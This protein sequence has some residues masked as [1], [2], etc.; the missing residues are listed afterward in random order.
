MGKRRIKQSNS[1]VS[2][3][4]DTV[5]LLGI[6]IAL[7]SV[8]SIVALSYP[9]Q[10]STPSTNIIGF[11]DGNNIILEHRGG[12]PLSLDTKILIKIGD[13]E[14]SPTA[15]D[16]LSDTNGDGHWNLDER[17][18]FN[19]GYDISNADIGVTVVDVASNSVVMMAGGIQG[20][21]TTI[22]SLETH[23]NPITP[24]N[25]G[26]SPFL[27]TA[28]GD[29][30]LNSVTLWY[31]WSKDNTSWNGGSRDWHND[32][33]DSAGSNVDGSLDKG[34]E[35]SFLNAQE[36]ARDGDYMTVQEANQGNENYNYV[37]AQSSL[38]PPT[39]IG[40]HSSFA[41]MQDFDGSYD[42]LSEKNTTTPT[43]DYVDVANAN[44][45]GTHSDFTAE[46]SGPNGVF[47]TLSEG[48]TG[49]SSTTK[50]IDN[51]SFEGTWPPTGWSET[52]DGNW[53]RES[54]QVY[55][56]TYSADWD[57]D[58]SGYLYS[59]T[60]SCSGSS[61]I[62][63]SFYFKEEVSDSDEFR[64]YF[65]DAD[66]NYD[67]IENLGSY[68]SGWNH[69]TMTITDSQYFS[70]N[71]QI[72]WRARNVDSGEHIYVDLVYVTKTVV[73]P[74]YELNLEVQWTSVDYTLPN[75]RLSIYAGTMASED[76]KVDIWNTTTSNWD[77]ALSDLT[78][79]WNNISV[80]KWLTSS[81]FTIRYRDGTP[82]SDSTPSTWQ[83]DVTLLRL[84]GNTNYQL[85]LEVQWTSADYD[86]TNEYLCIYGGTQ[87]SESLRVDVWNGA[88]TNVISDLSAGWNNVSVSSYLT[89][90]NFEIRF[91]DTTQSGDTS[92][93][94]WQ[95]EGVLL[96]TWSVATN[97]QIDF[98]YQW[99]GAY[100]NSQSE[101]LCMYIGSH[102]GSETLN[103]NYRS[104]SSW[105]SLGTIT[106][107]GWNNFTATGL[108]SST[109]TIQ[110]IG[111]TETSDISQDTWTVDC[112]FLKTYNTSG[113]SNG[114]DWMIW[115][116]ITNPDTV[117]PWS[118]SFNFPDGKGYYEFYSIGRYGGNTEAAPA[119]ADA[120]CHYTPLPL[121]VILRP[122]AA[123]STTDL[124]RSGSGGS[125][126]D[127]VDEVTSDED[128]TYVYSN[129]D[130]SF[131]TDTYNLENPSLTG[132]ITKV[133]VYINVRRNSESGGPTSQV[134]ARTATR[135]SS[136]S[137][138]YGAT[139]PDL[140]TSWTTYSTE[141]TTKQGNLGSG[142]WTWTDIN[143]LQIGVSLRSQNDYYSWN[144]HWSWA[145]C[146][147]VW[148][149]VTYTS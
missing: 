65:R 1:A 29:S 32:S 13:Q 81:T 43:I 123:G 62:Y 94:S 80:T 45:K 146:T 141:Y 34:T 149:E 48:N 135:I 37:D 10:P 101:T 15:K 40:T 41:E 11:V 127:R 79:G 77:N 130:G 76:I 47:D 109:Y 14:Y 35:T 134:S 91:V 44:N 86:E 144:D 131:R 115:Y 70:S 17:F 113:G 147:Q 71:F 23:V 136:G 106:A 58:G 26:S 6:A 51:Q 137:I 30:G 2:E 28:T 128:S 132:T 133:T 139:T 140:S 60:M 83:I 121:S 118:W 143:N 104:G 7:F 119:V 22:P 93:S 107:A 64:L 67:L 92:Q 57:D 27:I 53:N 9:F 102:T 3:V 25:Q 126:W 42:T 73:T 84:L 39:D 97:Y 122:N 111:A 12:E 55:H 56:G 68:P 129:N 110:L 8:V 120:R 20:E 33:V 95:V 38:H 138:E 125:N 103:V 61:S 31:R 78:T 54:D 87:D 69:W 99:T 117:S 16:N 74:N 59:P 4:L 46:Q 124:S 108:T 145:W 75:E 89:S 52:G 66:G 148:V 112:M 82:T 36:I 63:V 90:S 142:S 114:H 116:N 96:H 88:W 50:L 49:S 24:Y 5:L 85:D 19:P 105:T 72:G 18:V 21:G 98:E 100:F